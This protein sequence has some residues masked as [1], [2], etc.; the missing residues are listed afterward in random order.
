MLSI[1][2]AKWSVLSVCDCGTTY[3]SVALDSSALASPSLASF[4]LLVF[5]LLVLVLLGFVAGSNAVIYRLSERHVVVV[6]R[7]E[8]V[9]VQAVDHQ[10]GASLGALDARTHLGR[11]PEA[12]N[13]RS[14]VHRQGVERRGGGGADSHTHLFHVS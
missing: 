3:P 8:S 10:S 13:Q 5:V 9:L 1:R 12:R 6:G 11:I 2:T 7:G 14:Y 4:V